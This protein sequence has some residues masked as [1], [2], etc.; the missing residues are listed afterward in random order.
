MKQYPIMYSGQQIGYAELEKQGM[1]FI[2]HCFCNVKNNMNNRIYI[3]DGK[4]KIDLGLCVPVEKGVGLTV[5]MRSDQINTNS[6]NF[7]LQEM[8]K[9]GKLFPVKEGTPFDLIDQLHKGRFVR[10][11]NETY[12]LID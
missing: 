1:F 7:I 2:I 3:T 9:N 4:N 6:I 10:A 12:I 5:R 8:N 11:N